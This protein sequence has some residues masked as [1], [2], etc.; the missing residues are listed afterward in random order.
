MYQ[1]ARVQFPSLGYYP[2]FASL[3]QEPANEWRGTITPLKA[4]NILDLQSDANAQFV[5]TR[6]GLGSIDFSSFGSA[7]SS[8]IDVGGYSIPLVA[9]GVAVLV[10]P[11]LLGGARRSSSTRKARRLARL[12]GEV[13]AASI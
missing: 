6:G 8:T 13:A 11:L 2:G 1:A 10:L 9:I 5:G 4:G 3:A 7:L 12:K